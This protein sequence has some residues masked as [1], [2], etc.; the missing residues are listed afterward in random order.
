MSSPILGSRERAKVKERLA[1]LERHFVNLRQDLLTDLKSELGKG[2]GQNMEVVEGTSKIEEYDTVP[3]FPRDQHC[4]PIHL[5]LYQFL[6][7][8]SFS[9][10]CIELHLL[11]DLSEIL[12]AFPQHRPF[13]VCP[14]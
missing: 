14:F 12:E 3:Q 5:L 4:K 13:L 2:D 11:P 7:I 1:D 6:Q 9:D 10:C 8:F